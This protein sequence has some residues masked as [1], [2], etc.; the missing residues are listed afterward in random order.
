MP[1]CRSARALLE[2]TRTYRHWCS[3]VLESAVDE[4]IEDGPI[5]KMEE[6]ALET[7]GKPLLSASTSSTFNLEQQ[8]QNDQNQQVDDNVDDKDK[9]IPL[10]RDY[11]FFGI[12]ERMSDSMC[13]FYYTFR[14]PPPESL[15][16]ELSFKHRVMSCKTNS[17]WTDEDKA[18]VKEREQPDYAIWR[19]GNVIMDIWLERVRREIINDFFD[20]DVQA[21]T[22]FMSLD[23]DEQRNAQLLPSYIASGCFGFFRAQ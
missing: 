19:S 11:I 9:D 15:E 7:F 18:I 22:K 3:N 1:H 20:G 5:H 23:A 21:A 10:P 17:W 16:K 14:K 6:Y 4:Y 13:L 8:Q 2:S 12:T